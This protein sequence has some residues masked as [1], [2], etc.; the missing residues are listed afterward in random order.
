M[1]TSSKLAFGSS[2]ALASSTLSVHAQLGKV[3]S[4]V[5]LA[6]TLAACGGGG[7]GGTTTAPTTDPSGTPGANTTTLAP[8]TTTVAPPTPASISGTIYYVFAGELNKFELSTGKRTRL[9]GQGIFDD[10]FFDVSADNKEL[11]YV[12]DAPV[13][14]GGDYFEQEYFNF[15][16]T[17]SLSEVAPRF[18]KFAGTSIKTNFA[19]LSPDKT[20]LAVIYRYCSETFASG[21]CSGYSTNVRVWDKTGTITRTYTKDNAGN[22]IKEFAWMPGGNLLMT[23]AAGILKTTDATLNSYELLFK[24][25]LPSW[26]SVV[27]SPDGK[28]LA[29]KSGKHIYT[30]NIDGSNMVQL[31]DSEGDDQQY[32]PIWSPDGKYIAFTTNIFAYTTGPIVSGGGTI[33]QMILAPADNKTYKLTKEY[34]ESLG[35]GGLSGSSGIVA[36][37]GL[38]ILKYGPNSKVFA[39][40]DFVWR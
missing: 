11:M 29:L 40:E 10:K 15:V 38:V 12:K 24:P 30:M 39:E 2:G 3:F 1:T 8:P 7:G 23:S 19:K 13:A 22:L 27:P 36:N 5:A 18:K 25:N 9:L 32:S 20:K 4:R 21:V 6:I 14:D 34:F 37:N 35:S 17:T 31:T 26:R 33:Y 16:D 28:R